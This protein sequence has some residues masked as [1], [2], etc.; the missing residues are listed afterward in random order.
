MNTFKVSLYCVSESLE[1]HL[2]TKP[3]VFFANTEEDA[4]ECAL[5]AWWSPRLETSGCSPDFV[6]EPV[7]LEGE[8][9]AEQYWNYCKERVK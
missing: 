6:V 5:D 7:E 9:P 2:V 8:T 3:G 4:K 1:R